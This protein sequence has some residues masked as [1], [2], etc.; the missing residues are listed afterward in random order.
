MSVFWTGYEV[1]HCVRHWPD[2]F[3]QSSVGKGRQRIGST[4]VT[5]NEVLP[6]R[7][8][9]QVGIQIPTGILAITLI[10]KSKP[11]S[12]LTPIAVQFG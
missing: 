10:S 1:Y 8:D 6:Y 4:T 2:R 12:Q 7:A 11:A 9:L 5:L 3:G